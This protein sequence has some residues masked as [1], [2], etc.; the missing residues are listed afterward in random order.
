MAINFPNIDPVIINIYGPFSVTWYSMAYVTGIILGWAYVKKI[1][2]RYLLNIND[3]FIDDLITYTI[4]GIIIGGRL[5]YVIFY[6][7]SNYFHHPLEIL[8]TWNGGM[9]FHGGLWGLVLAIYIASRMAKQKFLSVMDIVSC[10][11]PIGIFFGRIANFIRGELYGRI[12]SEPWGMV[13]PFGGPLPRHPSQI[14]EALL[15]GVIIFVIQ[16]LLLSRTKIL[17]SQGLLGASF[18]IQYSVYRSFIEIFREPDR[19]IGFISGLTMGQ[20]LSFP[21][22]AIAL[23]LILRSYNQNKDYGNKI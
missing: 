14:Y 12:T 11:A 21:M 5:G 1:N 18:L 7:L 8:A 3:K 2:H 6:D 23:I 22:I 16:Y 9:S 10:V 19:N 15:E 13:F 4:I 17:Q 20:I